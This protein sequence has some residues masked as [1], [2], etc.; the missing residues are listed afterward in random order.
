MVR[1]LYL[2]LNSFFASCEQQENPSLQGR[3]VAV[4][5]LVA[6]TTAVLAASY[7]AKAKGI[8]TGTLV[9]EAKRLCPEL[10]LVKSQHKTYIS[11]HQKVRDVAA[12]SYTEDTLI[13]QFII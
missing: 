2:D 3:P 10:N 13:L 9:R 12:A 11:Y 8:K 1:W 6:E 5:P 7:E 4:V